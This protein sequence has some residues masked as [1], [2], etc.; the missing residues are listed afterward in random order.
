MTDNLPL[1]AI[2]FINV[3]VEKYHVN[4]LSNAVLSAQK[5][6]SFINTRQEELANQLKGVDSRVVG[7]KV[8]H[9]MIDIGAQGGAYVAGKEESQQK[10]Q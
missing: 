8:S 9:N 1:R 3:L 7:I 10:N 6:R 4:E 2:N 5:T